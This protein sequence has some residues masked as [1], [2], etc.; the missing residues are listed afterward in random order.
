MDPIDAMIAALSADLGITFKV[1]DYHEHALTEGSDASAAAY[2][3]AQGDRRQYLVGNGY[4]F[5][6]PRCLTR[7][8][9]LGRQS[10]SIE[11]L[12]LRGFSRARYGRR[13]AGRRSVARGRAGAPWNDPDRDFSKQSRRHRSSVLG[14]FHGGS[15]VGTI[16]VGFDGHRG[17]LYYVAVAGLFRGNDLGAAPRGRRPKRG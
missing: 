12:A 14:A 11:R 10:S 6:H 8:R 9:D 4:E 7:G 17:W 16:M 3:E 1:H 15:L 5:V 2:V 13:R